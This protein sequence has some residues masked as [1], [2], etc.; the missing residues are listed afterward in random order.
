MCRASGATPFVPL[1]WGSIVQRLLLALAAASLLAGC[2]GGGGGGASSS[3]PSPTTTPPPASY[4]VDILDTTTGYAPPTLSIHVG[5]K[6]RWRNMDDVVHTATSDMQGHPDT[7][8]LDPGET[9][10]YYTFMMPETI[11]YRCARHASMHGT[12]TVQ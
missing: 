3:S 8:D 4:T 10:P 1:R 9:T 6:V 7:G 5:D 12:I 2:F 11:T